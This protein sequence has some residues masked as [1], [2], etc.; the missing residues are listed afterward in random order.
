MNISN[1]FKQFP[2]ELYVF[3][4]RLE[5]SKIHDPLSTK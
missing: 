1:T 3:V 2:Y 4:S 5:L